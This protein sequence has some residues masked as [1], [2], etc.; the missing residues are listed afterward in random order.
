MEKR[1]LAILEPKEE[2]A[3]LLLNFIKEKKDFLFE[4]RVFT[5]LEALYSY[6]NEN[7]IDILLAA[8]TSDYKEA[9]EKAP[10]T[11][12]LTEPIKIKRREK[13]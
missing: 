3:G 8:K 13:T 10:F 11:I 12:L 5:K 6:M 7:K 4:T 2:Y 9:A 1:I